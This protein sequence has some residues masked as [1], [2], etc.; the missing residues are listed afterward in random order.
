MNCSNAFHCC[1]EGLWSRSKKS[2]DRFLLN[3]GLKLEIGFLVL[4]QINWERGMKKILSFEKGPM[5]LDL[6]IEVVGLF[7]S[8]GLIEICL[9]ENFSNSTICYSFCR[10]FLFGS[11]TLHYLLTF[12]WLLFQFFFIIALNHLRIKVHTGWRKSLREGS[13]SWGFELLFNWIW[14]RAAFNFSI[15][16]SIELRDWIKL[17]FSEKK[18][19][20]NVKKTYWEYIN[21]HGLPRF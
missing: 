5:S 19:L 17:L 9:G 16:F 13:K 8:L 10:H 21:L 2:S 18:S 12:F 4:S 11:M 14:G 15:F 3:A 20:C 7:R 6:C 1:D